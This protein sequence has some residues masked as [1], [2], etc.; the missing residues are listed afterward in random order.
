MLL[1]HL[2]LKNETGVFPASLSRKFIV[3]YVRLKC[4]YKGLIFTDDLKMH[5]IKFIYGAT[6]SVIKAFQAGNDIIVFRF[7]EKE[8]KQ[9]LNKIFKSIKN[10]KIKESQIN[11]SVNRI[12][13][14]KEKYNISDNILPNK[15]NVDDVNKKIDKI[16]NDIGLYT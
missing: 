8:E 13:K 2:L 4:R 9:A 12:I 10:G 1:G 5:S 3:K 7:T 11:R 14:I 15:I 16:R 6:N